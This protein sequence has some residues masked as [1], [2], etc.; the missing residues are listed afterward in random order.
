MTTP[1]R[2]HF[3][4]QLQ[5]PEGCLCCGSQGR[6]RRWEVE[7]SWPV[8]TASPTG[9]SHCKLEYLQGEH[10]QQLQVPRGDRKN[11]PEFADLHCT[12]CTGHNVFYRR[13]YTVHGSDLPVHAIHKVYEQLNN[14]RADLRQDNMPEL[15]RLKTQTSEHWEFQGQ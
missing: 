14:L 4:L 10:R 9:W 13:F 12:S 8:S 7:D 1:K 3:H 2:N 5:R 11:S 6:K 15:P